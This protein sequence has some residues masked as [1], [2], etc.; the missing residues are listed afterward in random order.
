MSDTLAS[1]LA[2]TQPARNPQGPGRPAPH[3]G[4]AVNPWRARLNAALLRPATKPIVFVALLLPLAWLVF[5]AA[6]DRLGANPAEALIRGLG[7]WTLRALILALAITPLRRWSG[8]TALARLRRMVGLYAFFYASCHLLAYAW[9][10]MG[11][12]LP[13]IARDIVKRPFILVGM[14]SFALL[15]PLA[16]T[17]FDAAVRRLGGARWRALHRAVYLIALL[18]LLHFFWMRAGKNDFAEWSV[19]AAIVAV[20]LGERLRWAFARRAG[21]GQPA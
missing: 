12:V 1:R 2:A 5:G 13:E 17:S 16:A 20:L 15:L 18:S 3:A 4:R 14:L 7:D 21:S 11:L 8:L 9:L 10:D 6:T 19:H